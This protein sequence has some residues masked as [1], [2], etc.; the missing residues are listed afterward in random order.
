MEFAYVNLNP[1]YELQSIKFPGVIR[2]CLAAAVCCLVYTCS[3]KINFMA[4]SVVPAAT[5]TITIKNTESNNYAIHI[6]I[7]HL[8]ESGRLQPAKRTYIAW[9]ETAG[10]RGKNIGQV[11]SKDGFFSSTYRKASGRERGA[12]RSRHIVLHSRW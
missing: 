6:K 12:A 9:I 1:L 11:K 4:S 2:F 10:S 3:P 7:L 8:A 5:G